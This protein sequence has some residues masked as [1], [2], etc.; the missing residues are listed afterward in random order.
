MPYKDIKA[1]RQKIN[2]A[3][4]NRRYLNG[5]KP[6]SENVFCSSYLGVHIAEKLL[7]DSLPQ[8]KRM[9]Y[10]N[11]YYDFIYLNRFKLDVKSACLSH[12]KD[13][14]SSYWF[15]DIN[16]NPKADLF[17][18]F[19]FNDRT[20]LELFHFWFIP[21]NVINSKSILC[22]TNTPNGLSKWLIYE[23]PLTDIKSTLPIRESKTPLNPNAT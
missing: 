2:L 6:L 1:N 12:P 23:K 14:N 13:K 17:A 4:K 15:F 18:L 3:A 8:L 16:L 5:A 22:I 9:P 21:A 19:A 11:R 10:N 7:F 20:D